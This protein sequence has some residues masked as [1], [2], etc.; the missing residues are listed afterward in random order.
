MEVVGLKCMVGGPADWIERWA[1][2]DPGPYTQKNTVIIRNKSWLWFGF[3]KLEHVVWILVYNRW[4]NSARQRLYLYGTIY[5]PLVYIVCNFVRWGCALLSRLILYYYYFFIWNWI[6]SLGKKTHIF[7]IKS[8]SK[9]TLYTKSN[10]SYSKSNLSI[11]P[12]NNPSNNGK[13]KLRYCQKKQKSTSHSL[14][15]QPYMGFD[16]GAQ[17]SKSKAHLALKFGYS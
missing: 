7:K 10:H 16:L 15:D 1:S 2:V 8:I 5:G 13:P 3:E 9:S 11:Q 12:K 6:F 17:I 14:T 4:L